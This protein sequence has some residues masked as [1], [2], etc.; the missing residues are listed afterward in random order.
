MAMPQCCYLAK[1]A[2]RRIP[3][4]SA[5]D[6]SAKTWRWTFR[7]KYM[8]KRLRLKTSAKTFRMQYGAY[9]VYAR[10]PSPSQRP[11]FTT[12]ASRSPFPLGLCS[13]STSLARWEY[14]RPPKGPRGTRGTGDISEARFMLCIIPTLLVLS[15]F[16]N[17]RI[18]QT[19]ILSWLC[20]WF[21]TNWT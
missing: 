1:G 11:A 5:K 17:S 12:I 13:C 18:L 19:G 20:F 8:P 10:S 9:P 2:K 21:S 7:Q 14:K 6:V 16:F 3:D 4:V 15:F